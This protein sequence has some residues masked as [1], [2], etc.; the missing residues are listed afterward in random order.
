MINECEH[1]TEH[2]NS[3]LDMNCN[4]EEGIFLRNNFKNDSTSDSNN[5]TKKHAKEKLLAFTE[6]ISRDS[7]DSF[8]KLT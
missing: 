7:K 4:T 5:T 1:L 3:V 8:S 6:E 2:I